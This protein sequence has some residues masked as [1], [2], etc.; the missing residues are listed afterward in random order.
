M[1]AQAHARASS[2]L[3]LLLGALF[4]LLAPLSAQ[5][6]SGLSAD[7][8]T[9]LRGTVINSVTH[10]PVPHA[11]VLSTD[12]RFATMA[13]DRGHFEFPFGPA[14]TTNS[15]GVAG[16]NSPAMEKPLNRPYDLMARKP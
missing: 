14:P 10:E 3:A 15:P 6:P 5:S 9:H 4:F 16:P 11:L 1:H 8:P 7:Q 2:P 12:S 13:D